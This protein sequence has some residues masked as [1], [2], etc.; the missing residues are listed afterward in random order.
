MRGPALLVQHRS[1]SQSLE[2][3]YA[4]LPRRTPQEID[5]LSPSELFV[6]QLRQLEIERNA[7]YNEEL[8]QA[9]AREEERQL[10][11]EGAIIAYQASYDLAWVNYERRGMR[12]GVQ[13]WRLVAKW[14]GKQHHMKVAA[15]AA[16]V[17]AASAKEHADERGQSPGKW[18]FFCVALCVVFLGGFLQWRLEQIRS[19]QER[20]QEQL[21]ASPP[22]APP[23]PSLSPWPWL[24]AVL[25]GGALSLPHGG[26]G[27][28]T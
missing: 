23:A 7:A 6:A 14:R 28:L 20:I 24:L 27:V 15:A 21:A 3:G 12:K 10:Q 8:Q 13:K 19:E 26:R 2:A 25:S 18:Y 5:S 17:T 11:S 4:P 16:P 22:K 1:V 9:L